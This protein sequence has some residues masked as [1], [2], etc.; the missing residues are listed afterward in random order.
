MDFSVRTN[1]VND[2]R[3]RL[4]AFATLTIGNNFK[5]SG[6]AVLHKRDSDEY[7]IRMPVYKTNKIDENGKSI[8]KPIC[9]PLTGEFYKEL[10]DAVIQAMNS[11]NHQ[12]TISQGSQVADPE[13]SIGVGLFNDGKGLV[14]LGSISFDKQFIVNTIRL[15]DKNN[16]FR[17]NMPC[18]KA[19]ATDE[20]GKDVFYDICHPVTK[21][22]RQE[23]TDVFR[24]NYMAL[25]EQK[26][27]MQMP[28]QGKAR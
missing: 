12:V 17:L 4:K 8:Y 26:D 9:Q 24:L 22:F 21:E 3:G 13:Y 7:Y 2:E 18:K 15:Y 25:K 1:E 27:Q 28:S 16:R 11:P 6:I 5:I 23:L 20:S 14:G 19:A 10:H